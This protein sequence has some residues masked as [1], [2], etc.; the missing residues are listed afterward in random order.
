M[1]SVRVIPVILLKNG[2]VV[3]SKSFSRHQVL[4]N[5]SLI[6][7]R[8]SNWY[9]DELIYLDISRHKHYDLKRDDL[10]F[11]NK[12]TILEIIEDCSRQCF[13]PLTVGG[14]I[15]TVKDVE[16][17]LRSGADKVAINSEAFRNPA[18]IK[19]CAKRFG[20]QCIV[21]S[22]DAKKI[23]NNSWEVFVGY[24][25]EPTGEHPDE[26]AKKMQAMGAGEIIINSIDQDGRGKGFDVDL[27]RSVV[28]AVEIPVIALGGAGEWRHFAECL[29]LA[30]PNAVAASNIFQYT[31]NSVY[32]ANKYLFEQNYKVRKP[33]IKTI[34]AA[35]DN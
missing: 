4:G 34:I 5:A 12:S 15:R 16:D 13:M 25:K 30:Y 7:S 29:D 1:A 8:F 2:R 17:R 18:L 33:F 31:E 21:V 27:V 22:I 19:E 14:G 28:E 11:E 32:N 24:G 23:S 9:A 35:G 6:V 3:Q 20:S 26:W 10:N